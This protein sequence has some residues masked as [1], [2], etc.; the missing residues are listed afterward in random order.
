[1]A[2][3]KSDKSWLSSYLTGSKSHVDQMNNL[4]KW[5]SASGQR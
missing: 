4:Q 3:L 1:M 5:A 2:E